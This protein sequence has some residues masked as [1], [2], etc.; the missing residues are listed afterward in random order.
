ML[1]AAVY[2]MGRGYTLD[3]V[4][5][6]MD[7][8]VVVRDDGLKTWDPAFLQIMRETIATL[9]RKGKRR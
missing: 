6:I 2:L 4:D 9:D 3:E 7:P 8:F 1:G 5:T